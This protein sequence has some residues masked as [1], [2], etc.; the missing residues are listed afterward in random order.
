M[1][2][3]CRFLPDLLAPHVAVGFDAGPLYGSL[4]F[5]RVEA[6]MLSC[7]LD[8]FFVF[9]WNTVFA[10]T[11]CIA[12]PARAGAVKVAFRSLA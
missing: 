4:L 8:G 7:F 6:A 9:D 5:K 11:R 2:R 3:I 1:T 12:K 10:P